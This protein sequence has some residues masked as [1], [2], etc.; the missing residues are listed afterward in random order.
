MWTALGLLAVVAL[1]LAN[2][3]FVAAEFAFVASRRAKL[4][5]RAE[6][7]DRRARHAVRVHKRLSFMLSGA[8]LGITVTSLVVGFIAEPTLGQALE[9]VMG[10]VG[11]PERAQAGVALSVGFVLATAAQMVVGELAPKNLAI[12]KPEP[13]AR[14]LAG[15]TLVFLRLAGPLIRVF[16]GSANRLLRA[17]G[18]EPVDELVGGISVEELDII[19]EES[20]EHGKLSVRQAALMER[21]IDFGTLLAAAAMVPWN[22]VSTIPSTDTCED[23]RGK[24]REAHSRFPVVDEDGGVFG[25]VH[26]KDLLDVDDDALHTTPVAALTR[27]PLVVPETATLRTVLGEL[28]KEGTEMAI[29]A[30]EHGGPAGVLTLEDIVEEL[31]GDISDEY[32]PALPEA[33]D[34]GDGTWTVPG[35]LRHDEIARSTGIELP[36]GEGYDTVAGLVMSQLQRLGQVGDRVEVA[37]VAIE[38]LA[39]EGWAITSV[40]LTPLVVDDEG[41]TTP[42]AGA[43]AHGASTP[44]A[45]VSR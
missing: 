33:E 34:G 13:I 3:Y 41:R 29:V 16:D 38:V 6:D 7:G 28:R 10:A 44:D 42:I 27:P 26:A 11:V 43:S 37:G 40:R 20:A 39:L 35:R 32:D 22:R 14:A 8:Q 2:G 9:P 23:L 21:A 19:V 36:E 4:E 17:V 31:V 1:I 25:V 24:V 12:A 30:D 45:K 18:I 5:E 15:S